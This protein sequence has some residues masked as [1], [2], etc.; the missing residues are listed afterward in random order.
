MRMPA[1]KQTT[2]LISSGIFIA[3]LLLPPEPALSQNDMVD[4]AIEAKKVGQGIYMLTGRGGNLGLS[5]GVDGAF[6]IDDQ[7]APLTEKITAAVA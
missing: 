2:A 1:R 7:F 3:L 5:V 4:V 6:L